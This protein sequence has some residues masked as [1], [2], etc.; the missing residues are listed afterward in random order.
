MINEWRVNM[1]HQIVRSTSDVITQTR[2]FNIAVPNST[3]VSQDA[4]QLCWQKPR[5]G[6]W[7]CNVDVSV[8]QSL[9]ATC[10]GWCM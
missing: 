1:M 10:R 6:W 4:M 2:R 5:E 3:V 8:L 7:K 9:G